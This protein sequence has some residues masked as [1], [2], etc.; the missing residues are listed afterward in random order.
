MIGIVLCCHGTMGNGVR[1]AAE[2]IVGEQEQIAV[3]GVNPGDQSEEILNALKKAISEVDSGDGTLLITDLFGGTPTNIS[4]V[5][6]KEADVEVVTGLN[7]PLLIKALAARS[8]MVEL[9]ELART[10]SQYG[11]RHISVAGEL[12][13]ETGEGKEPQQG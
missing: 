3:V 10:A 12:L 1:S 9:S 6:L 4:C 11:R 8:D 2:M 13:Q 7:L 5:L